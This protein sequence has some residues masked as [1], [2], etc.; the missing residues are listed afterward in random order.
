MGPDTDGDGLPDDW[1]RTY[2]GD[3]AM[4]ADGL[5]DNDGD[6]HSNAEEYLADTDPLNADSYL[7][8]TLSDFGAGGSPVTL[9]WASRPTRVYR[10]LK[11][12]AFG[13]SKDPPFPWMDAGLGVICPDPGPT[14]TRSLLDP[15]A[16]MQF[17][18]IQAGK[19]LSL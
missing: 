16:S 2:A 8:I 19:P 17:F 1:E 4:L 18:E 13:P 11:V 7:H 15:A 3:L 14:T 10:L 9:T 5:A 12:N 6:G